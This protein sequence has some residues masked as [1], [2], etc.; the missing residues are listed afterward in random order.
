MF[1]DPT[2]RGYAIAPIRLASLLAVC[3]TVLLWSVRGMFAPADPIP[4]GSA[5]IVGAAARVGESLS[6]AAGGSTEAPLPVERTRLPNET[7]EHPFV[8]FAHGRVLDDHGDGI[9]GATVVASGWTASEFLGV[10]GE[11]TTGSDGRYRLV[12]A[13]DAPR[14]FGD[15]DFTRDGYLER[16]TDQLDIRGI[17]DYDVGDRILRREAV[18]RGRVES[19][20]GQPLAGALVFTQNDRMNRA[21]TDA[22]GNFELRRVPPGAT[23][24]VAE[25][26]GFLEVRSPDRQPQWG[27]PRW[28]VNRP[29]VACACGEVIQGLRLTL[30]PCVGVRVTFHDASTHAPLGGVRLNESIRMSDREWE[31][32][33]ELE[34]TSDAKG[35]CWIDTPAH[36]DCTMK[37]R[38]AGFESMS[39]VPPR[40]AKEPS[41]VLEFELMPL[42]RAWIHV[43]DAATGACLAPVEVRTHFVKDGTDVESISATYASGANP[44]EILERG[45]LGW[46]IGF[47]RAAD[48]AARVVFE[49]E[50][51]DHEVVR[52]ND[53]AQ[54][55][56]GGSDAVLDV[57]VDAP[58]LSHD[59]IANRSHGVACEE[60]I[61]PRADSFAATLEGRILV[62]ATLDGIA[63]GVN[64]I[65]LHSD[66]KGLYRQVSVCADAGG[67]YSLTLPSPGPWQVWAGKACS[68]RTDSL[69][70]DV[71][72]ECK[73]AI[74]IDVANGDTLERDLAV[75][76]STFHVIEGV[77][78]IGGAPAVG[79]EVDVEVEGASDSPN[80]IVGTNGRIRSA[81]VFQDACVVVLYRPDL[82][83]IA[84]RYVDFATM[85][86][87]VEFDVDL[88]CVEGRIQRA[89][90]REPVTLGSVVFR[91][92][93]AALQ[94]PERNDS[95]EFTVPIELDGSYSID[96][97]P[98][99][100]YVM[101]IEPAACDRDL[102]TETRR[103][104]IPNVR[105][106]VVDAE[107]ISPGG[108]DLDLST[109][110]EDQLAW[111]DWRFVFIAQSTQ[112]E[113]EPE[114]CEL[115]GTLATF[116]R[117]PVD[118]YRIEMRRET[119][120]GDVVFAIGSAK[121]RSGLRATAI[122]VSTGVHD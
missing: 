121:V 74:A 97:M 9:E 88:V 98:A 62:P 114:R 48:P 71:D 117:L 10:L 76:P 7:A 55:T 15:I 77:A 103:V 67:L 115:D 106:V 3:S 104:E 119:D 17:R 78:R 108:I 44:T 28:T 5:E 6:S 116:E 23:R 29:V 57:M 79:Y 18:L 95:L 34:A 35:E 69:E 13:G 22:A 31:Q 82:T 19:V 84:R 99:G 59:E 70:R 75:D 39:F 80:V 68:A 49:V 90:G 58:A 85:P 91:T 101:K 65:Q 118:D 50:C 32:W 112:E 93:Q 24:V 96:A 11:A 66:A 102:V 1:T 2:R 33:R 47:P 27:E 100:A 40:E 61:S 72:T 92:P 21:T 94:D 105:S 16:S 120:D 107:M 111:K 46:L 42:R 14:E 30:E 25:K 20:D 38:L 51:L 122:A 60:P 41:T 37:A 64:A 26:D 109:I 53:F 52:S 43:R 63:L 56:A 4:P 54:P 12:L 8:T 81:P 89:G 45:S 113:L 86:P 87:W 83:A 73:G 110:P 36:G